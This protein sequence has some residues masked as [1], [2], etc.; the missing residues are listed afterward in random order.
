MRESGKNSIG[1]LKLALT[2]FLFSICTVLV[3]SVTNVLSILLNKHSWY[4]ILLN[5]E[6]EINFG[7][8]ALAYN[9]ELR[10]QDCKLLKAV[11]GYIRI[12]TQRKEN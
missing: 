5:K 12:Y 10:R 8:M 2:G 1:L 3:C 9:P 6:P 7:H 4:F 11:L